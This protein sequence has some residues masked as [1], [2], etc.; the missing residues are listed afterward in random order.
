MLKK[1]S[2]KGYG[3]GYGGRSAYSKRYES[4]EKEH[5]KVSRAVVSNVNQ[6]EQK[7]LNEM[8]KE[9]Q[10]RVRCVVES[11]HSKQQRPVTLSILKLIN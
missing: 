8:K 4:I 3:S 5:E 10:R 2:G 11:R 7:R 1:T 6:Q 9:S